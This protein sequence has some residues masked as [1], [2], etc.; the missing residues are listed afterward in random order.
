MIS[1]SLK[2]SALALF[3]V[4]SGM[5]RSAAALTYR[6]LEK[7]LDYATL[8]TAGSAK[9]HL[10]KVDLKL[11][12]IKVLDARDFKV[13]ALSVKKLAEK[14]QALVAINANFFDRDSRPLGLVLQEGRLK[15]PPKKISW[16]A[17]LLLKNA[18]AKIEK[19]F[20]PAAPL[21]YQNA[22]QAGPRLV[23]AGRTPKL[24]EEVSAKSAVG[25]DRQGKVVFIA[26]E[27]RI[28]IN[29]LA[30][31]LAKKE[32]DGG[33]G[34]RDALNLDGGSSTQLFARAGNLD[35]W[36]SG[37]SDVPIALGVVRK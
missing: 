24:K 21:P 30:A 28:E 37:F 13:S 15:N 34:L 36:I 22:V 31:L 20:D 18:S 12:K 25:I 19:I 11:F 2:T 9:L 3:F 23:V 4:V 17:G 32:Q 29:R 27:G 1:N 35:L 10:L 5:P 33:V 6:H 26:S 8:E 16:W 7:G 14:N